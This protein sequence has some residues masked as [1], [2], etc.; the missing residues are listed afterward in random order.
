MQ[1]SFSHLQLLQLILWSCK[2]HFYTHIFS[3]S[4]VLVN[5]DGPAPFFGRALPYQSSF[6]FFTDGL[7]DCLIASSADCGEFAIGTPYYFRYFLPNR[8]FN[9]GGVPVSATRVDSSSPE[10][11]REVTS[12]TISLIEMPT[13]LLEDAIA[14]PLDFLLVT[15]VHCWLLI[16]SRWT[17]VVSP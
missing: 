9:V 6:C 17:H 5:F 11:V 4:V 1:L 10:L 2:S 15:V 7:V 16:M 13:T 3:L 14:L 12:S 8:V